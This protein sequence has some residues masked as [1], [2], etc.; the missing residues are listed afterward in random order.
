MKVISGCQTGADFGGLV[1][2]CKFGMETGGW[3]PP[4]F[5][6]EYGP[7]PQWAEQFGLKECSCPVQSIHVAYV[8]RTKA[9]VRDSDGTIRFATDWG[10]AGETCTLSAIH[11]WGKPF[12]DVD[13]DRPRDHFEVV[14]WIIDYNIKVLNVAGNRES[15]SLGI[16]RFVVEYLSKVFEII[17]FEAVL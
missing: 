10:S 5:I 4:G 17:G 3:M 9:N 1:A 11:A 15:K 6:T 7:R 16:G 12:I 2:A 14:K 13:L 8:I